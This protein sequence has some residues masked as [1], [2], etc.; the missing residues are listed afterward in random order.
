VNFVLDTNAVSETEKPRP[1][2]GYVAWRD[3]QDRAHLFVTTITLAEVWQG[4]HSLEPNHPDY[5]RIKAI[6][7]EL[8]RTYRV[9]NFDLRAAAIWGELTAN[10]GALP[11]RDS[12]IGAIARSRGYQ[13][14]TRDIRP[15]QRMGCKVISPWQ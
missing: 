5:N 12:F 1:N 11:L 4:F 2:P 15:F 6:A 10:A 3:T 7:M 8:P 14:V 13:V 9:L